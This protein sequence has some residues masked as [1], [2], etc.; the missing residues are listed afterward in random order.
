MKGRVGIKKKLPL[1]DP[2]L[3]GLRRLIYL[4]YLLENETVEMFGMRERSKS[5]HKVGGLL[6]LLSLYF[7]LVGYR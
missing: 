3:L 2:T 5:K 7:K 4:G 6:V 1:K